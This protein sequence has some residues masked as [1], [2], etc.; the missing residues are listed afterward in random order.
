MRLMLAAA[1]LAAVALGACSQGSSDPF[2][3]F[4]AKPA[5]PEP[6]TGGLPTLNARKAV[7]WPEAG[8]PSAPTGFTV[9]R[10][11]S[12]LDHPRWL[13]VLPNGDVLVSEAT[14]ETKP[15]KS[16][17]GWIANALQ[18][19][20]GA[21]GP[22]PN[23]IVLLRD[24]DGD[25]VAEMKTDFATGLKRPFGMTLVG[26]TLY[27]ANDDAVVKFP[28]AHGQISVTGAGEKVFDLPGGPINHHWTKNVIAS[29][30]GSKLYATVG[31][32]SNIGENGIENETSR[33]AVLE[34]A[35]P[36]GPV[37]VY[38]SGLRNPNG[39]D[40]EPVTGALWTAV[41]ERDMIGDDL[42]PDYMTSLKDGG[43]YGWPYSYYGRNV[44][45]RV[46]PS[47]PDLV[48]KA[49]V[50]D[51]ALGPHTA[52]LGLAF[53]KADAFPA[54]YRGGVFIGQHGSWNRNPPNGYRVVFVP[55]ANGKPT[56]PPQAFLTGFLDA[57]GQARGRPVGVAVDK[58]GALLVADDVGDI[59]WRVAPTILAA[60]P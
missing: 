17:E 26:D 54:A 59:V 37:R 16:I 47:R 4:G 3:G 38:A 36:A 6:K 22:S 49:I 60:K 30:D 19:K 43:F 1:G 23:K 35:L 7:G 9:T 20:A 50:P 33:A 31:S 15:A 24:A 40:W 25:G 52:S 34:Y 29:P 18:R 2:V 21:S 10:F 48:A 12:G 5:L 13:L 51:Y 39:L 28:Y 56:G 58:T 42:V 11:G 57:K 44:D 45:A 14:T 55:F 27:V 32:N 41:N 53:Y 8:Q 46:K